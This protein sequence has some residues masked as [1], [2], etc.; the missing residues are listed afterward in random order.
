[1]PCSETRRN[2][3]RGIFLDGFSAMDIAEPL[4]SFDEGAPAREVWDFMTDRKFD[5]VGVRQGGLVTGYV[6]RENL[7]SGTCGDHQCPF[8]SEDDL[9]PDTASLTDVVASLAVN[10]QCFVTI[11]DHVGAIITLSDLEKPAMRMFLFGVITVDEMVMTEIILSRY[12][13]SSWQELISPKRLEK[14]QQMREERSRRG[15]DVHLIDCL[16]FGDKGWILSYDEEIRGLMGHDS[17]KSARKAIRE[18]ET[19]RNNLAHSQEIIP[20]SWSRIVTSCSRLEYNI[21][22]FSNRLQPAAP[23]KIDK[24]TQSPS[25]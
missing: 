14:A 6:R 4:V 12:G 11:L 24:A 18:L 9:V 17:R 23:T 19:L 15:Q 20:A 13:E 16:Q 2:R 3:L 7:I 10:E 22:T 5:L 25:A 21:D 1:M 8:A